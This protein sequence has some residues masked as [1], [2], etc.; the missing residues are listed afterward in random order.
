MMAS[1]ENNN[2]IINLN[3]EAIFHNDI[4]LVE[5]EEIISRDPQVA[6]ILNPYFSNILNLLQKVKTCSYKLQELY[7]KN[8]DE[9][10]FKEELSQSLYTSDIDTMKYEEFKSIF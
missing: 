8:F 3:N 10:N 9:I 2:R 4:T 5:N 7:Y 1:L 6:E